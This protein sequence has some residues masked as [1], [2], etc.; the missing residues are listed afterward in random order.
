[1]IISQPPILPFPSFKWRWASVAPTEGL[2]NPKI[3]IGVLRALARNEGK[4]PSSIDLLDDLAVVQDETNTEIDLVRTKERN[5]IRNSGQ[6][7]KA[8]DLLASSNPSIVM[9]PYGRALAS[10][11]I[12]K[13]EFAATA[14]ATLELPNKRIQRTDEVLLWEK[15]NIKI[16]PLELIIKILALLKFIDPDQCYLTKLELVK[17]IMPLSAWHTSIDDFADTILA[18]RKKI[19]HIDAWPNCA[20]DANDHRM[21]AEFL[22][23]LHNYGYLTVATSNNNWNSRYFLEIKDDNIINKITQ[24]NLPDD[25]FSASKIISTTGVADFIERQR[26]LREVL[27]RPRQSKFR[28]DILFISGS[29]CLITGTQL[30]AALEAAHIIPVKDNGSDIMDNGLCLRSDIHT[31][32]DNGHMRIDTQGGIHL[33]I[34]AKKDNV[35]KNLPE[36]IEIP[37]YVNAKNIEWRWNYN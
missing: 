14:I 22:I 23:F 21:A 20:P 8:F 2:N 16:K 10:G 32:Y 11:N 31:L 13:S 6:Y 5:L 17:I 1:M 19:L 15:N 4:A 28:K 7:W 33:S 3:F 26:T 29:Q 27:D 24:T 30:S 36:K 25:A 12:T 35:Y 34:L 37:K 18:F 9:T